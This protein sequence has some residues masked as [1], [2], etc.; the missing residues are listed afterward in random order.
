MQNTEKIGFSFEKFGLDAA[1]IKFD[2]IG[3]ILCS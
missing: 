3:S 2:K 1:L